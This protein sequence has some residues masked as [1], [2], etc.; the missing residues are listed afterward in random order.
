MSDELERQLAQLKPGDHICHIYS[1]DLERMAVAVPFVRDGLSRG[2]RCVYAS[3]DAVGGF[4]EALNAAGIEVARECERGRLQLLTKRD[5]YLR[6]GSFA[7]EAMMGFLCQ[8]E[9]QALA[10]G[11]SGLRFA[12][13]MTWALGPEPGCDRLIEYEAMLNRFVA[14]GRSV[15][16]C[17]YDH[18]RFGLSYIHDVLLTHPVAVLGAL[19]C[20]NP[21]YEPPELVLFPAPNATA[22][23]KAKRV[24]WWIAQL[25]RARVDFQER[26]TMF[27]NLQALSRQLIGVQESE[28]RHLARELHDEIGQALTGLRLL[29]QSREDLPTGEVKARCEQVRGIVDELLERIRGLSFDLRPSALDQL[30]LLPA[31]LT[32]FERFTSQTGILVHFKHEGIEGRFAPEVETTAY[33]ITQEALTNVARHAGV[34]EATVRVWATADTLNIQI[35]DRGSGFDPEVALA[36]PASNG[37]AGMRERVTLLGGHMSIES[38]PGSG[39]QLTAQLPLTDFKFD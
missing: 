7:P 36:A 32:L 1:S 2:D 34:R 37:L 27:R 10:D 23:F 16:L 28:R 3:D 30:G 29:V 33:R 5:S 12:S 11:F 31:L 35:E 4:V 9:A 24:A 20:P 25:K 6:W 8:A 13:E 17:Q 19:V 22:E 26:E 15:I 18:S 14:G 38:C 39:T 21:Y